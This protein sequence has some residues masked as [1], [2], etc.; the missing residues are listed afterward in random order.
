MSRNLI[1]DH[2]KHE[3]E[4]KAAS[5][6]Y[7]MGLEHENSTERFMLEQ[8]YGELLNKA[9]DQL[10]PQQK[11][12]FRLAK[13]EGLSQEAIANQLNLTRLTVKTHMK[14]ALQNIRVQLQGHITS[15]VVL[16]VLSEMF[17]SI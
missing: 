2:L 11:Q 9:V 8:Q 6:E 5:Q 3:A 14:K 16:M 1:F 4:E 10:P 17:D 13:I 12:I 7:A 15:G